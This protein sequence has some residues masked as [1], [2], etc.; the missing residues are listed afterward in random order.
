LHK[1]LRRARPLA[2]LLLLLALVAS[3]CGGGGDE[4]E[5]ETSDTTAADGPVDLS[6]VTLRVADL[7][8]AQQAAWDA[9]GLGAD[10]PYEIEWSEFPAGPPAIEAINAGAVDLSVM[11][12]TPPIFAQAGGVDV[13]V[14]GVARP[15]SEDQPYLQ[16]LVPEESDIE[17]VA[18]LEGK[19][20]AVAKQ[21]I[22]QYFLIRALE[23]EGLTLDDIEPA[24]LLPAEGQA[25]YQSGSADAF[26]S[27]EPL[28]TVVK[29]ARPSRAVAS[30]QDYFTS[31]TLAVARGGALDD[32]ELE[33]AIGD[34]LQRVARIYR[35]QLD[36]PEEW[37][38]AY[39]AATN[40]PTPLA[41]TTISSTAVAWQAID[42]D[43]I[44]V[45]QEQID[46]WAGLKLVPDGL[47]AEDEFDLRFN[48]LIQEATK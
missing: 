10:A 44:A 48:D 32:P 29:G 3:A 8:G 41:T 37:L 17:S 22:L 46:T 26:V 38:A 39:T 35:W 45:Q 4:A 6:G 24:Y 31:Q 42:D 15:V 30:S 28:T 5:A 33:A 21:T 43:V 1:T 16:I 40:Y 7:G 14:V 18:D 12:D 2:V 23:E 20:V 25:A 34:H 11:G 27:I 19:K 47:K 13:K 36:N 9:S